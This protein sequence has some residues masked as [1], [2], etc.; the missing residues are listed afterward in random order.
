MIKVRD[1]AVAPGAKSPLLYCNVE[2]EKAL[3][4]RISASGLVRVHDSYSIRDRAR[5]LAAQRLLVDGKDALIERLG[6]SIPALHL[7]ESGAPPHS[8]C[9]IEMVL[10]LLAAC[11]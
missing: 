6:L 3:G 9:R 5:I 1:Y 2:L 10:A 8:C 4:F 11:Q 7:I